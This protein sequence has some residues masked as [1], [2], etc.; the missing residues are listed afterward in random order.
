MSDLIAF[1]ILNG[2]LSESSLTAN[3]L[4]GELSTVFS[5]EGIVDQ[6][7]K[8]QTYSGEYDVKPQF[9]QDQELK[10][11]NRILDENIVVRQISYFETPTLNGGTTVYIGMEE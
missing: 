9:G 6:N 7:V 5:I 4:E 11:Q 2:E 3:L 8:Y 10:T 1:P